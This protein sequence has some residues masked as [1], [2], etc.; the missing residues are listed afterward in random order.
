M[1]RTDPGRYALSFLP[2]LVLA[3]VLVAPAPAA[4][5][6][7]RLGV[8]VHYWKTV[9]EL[10]DDPL[11]EIDDSGLAYVA[12]YQL[13]PA[14]IFKLQLDLEFFP[15][16]FLGSGEEAWSPQAYLVLGQRLYVAAGAGAVYSEGLEGDFSDIFYAA[17]IGTDFLIL[18]R[19]RF[20]LNANYR[21]AEWEQLD[22]VDTD[23]VTL[24][25]VLR[26]RL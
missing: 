6:E 25:A 16:G 5:V 9:D 7:H 10:A 8:G 12:S 26:L 1:R 4:A 19:L 18:P 23:L 11:G 14:G 13:V 3:A 17:R 20:D 15:Q 2:G 24:G 21:F 22:Q